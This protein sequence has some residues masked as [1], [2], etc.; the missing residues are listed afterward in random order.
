MPSKPRLLDVQ[1]IPPTPAEADAG[2]VLAKATLRAATLLGLSG[3]QLAEV[4]GSSESTVSRMA[5]GARA[6]APRSKPGQLATLVIRVY[7]SLDALVGNDSQARLR[8]M[9]S[10]NDAL[11]TTPLQALRTPEGLVRVVTY[12]DGAR[13]LA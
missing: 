9:Q 7:R 13:A 12:L 6:L 11:G 10:Y 2:R 8:W 3:R 5:G 1:A 4:I